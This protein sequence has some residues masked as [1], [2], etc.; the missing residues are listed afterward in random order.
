MSHK[1]YLNDVYLE[2][3]EI[4]NKL[5]NEF[6][7]KPKHVMNVF[8]FNKVQRKAFTDRDYKNFKSIN[9]ES[10]RDGCKNWGP[11]IKIT[12][13][14]CNVIRGCRYNGW[15]WKDIGELFD[16]HCTTPQKAL[17]HYE[18]LYWAP[19]SIVQ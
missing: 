11:S 5:I 19:G 3:F 10:V 15:T 17:Q 2:D 12:P 1:K 8:G 7:Y 18:T 4:A 13:R 9:D 16:A 14:A 6:S